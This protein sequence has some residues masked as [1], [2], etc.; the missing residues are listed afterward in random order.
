[1]EDWSETRKKLE[2]EYPAAW[3]LYYKRHADQFS[4]EVEDLKKKLQESETELRNE[5]L[6]LSVNRLE[7]IES[8]NKQTRI[9]CNL[10]AVISMATVIISLIKTTR[11]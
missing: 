9:L 7:H 11:L 3:I 5:K 1:M 4:K 10:A 6:S 8:L 2:E